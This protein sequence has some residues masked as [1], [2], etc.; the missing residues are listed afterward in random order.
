MAELLSER[1][2]YFIQQLREGRGCRGVRAKFE[3]VVTVRWPEPRPLAEPPPG[4]LAL[5]QVQ[6]ER[7]PAVLTVAVQT[8]GQEPQT[9]VRKRIR[10]R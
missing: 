7:T 3:I 1:A 9:I 2:A 8:Q 10:R 5:P 4:P 6:P